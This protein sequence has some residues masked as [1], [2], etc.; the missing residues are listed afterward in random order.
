MLGAAIEFCRSRAIETLLIT[1]AEDKRCLA[2]A[3]IESNG[4]ALERVAAGE[5]RYWIRSKEECKSGKASA[6]DGRGAGSYFTT[7]TAPLFAFG[8]GP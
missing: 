2:P 7:P 4:G 3:S 5:A 6:T 1:C 8:F